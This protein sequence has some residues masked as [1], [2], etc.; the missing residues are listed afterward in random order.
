MPSDAWGCVGYSPVAT[1]LY[2]P[3][4]IVSL[5]V[6]LL[7]SLSDLTCGPKLWLNDDNNF[8]KYQAFNQNEVSVHPKFEE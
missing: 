6:S 2:L 4:L 1:T 5:F 8:N 7:V 3:G